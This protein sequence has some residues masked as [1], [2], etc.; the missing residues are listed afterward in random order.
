LRR[1]RWLGIGIGERIQLQSKSSLGGAA[2]NIE[3][4]AVADFA[5]KADDCLKTKLAETARCAVA[6]IQLENLLSATII[7]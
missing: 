5:Q 7:A 6:V 1:S 3:T 4:L 2:S